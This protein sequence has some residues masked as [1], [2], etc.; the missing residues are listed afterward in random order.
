METTELAL[1]QVEDIINEMLNEQTNVTVAG[2]TFSPS[3]VL[4]ACDPI[5]YRQMVIQ[6]ADAN[7]VEIV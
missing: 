2:Q 6:W 5:A 3:R 7:N 1:D 4:K